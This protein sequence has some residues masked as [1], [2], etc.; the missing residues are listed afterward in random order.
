MDM[1]LCKDCR[2]VKWR[3]THF[4]SQFCDHPILVE[5]FDERTSPYR[6]AGNVRFFGICGKEG[7][8][9]EAKETKST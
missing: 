5:M 9:W 7:K 8:L 6:L 3:G 4:K 2:N 1:K